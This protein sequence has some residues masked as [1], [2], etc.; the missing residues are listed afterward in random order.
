ML[1]VKACA[2]I[3]ASVQPSRQEASK[4]EP[5]AGDRAGVRGADGKAGRA[6]NR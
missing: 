1:I 2:I 6:Q 5:A 4:F 3:S